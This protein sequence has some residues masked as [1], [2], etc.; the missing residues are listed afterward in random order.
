VREGSEFSLLPDN[1]HRFVL[2]LATTANISANAVPEP[3]AVPASLE[4][5][6]AA[7]MRPKGRA[8][9]QRISTLPFEDPNKLAFEAGG[10]AGGKKKA[11]KKPK[12][13]E[14]RHSKST[15]QVIDSWSV[16]AQRCS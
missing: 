15:K 5:P 11:G 13:D 6:V 14:A 7:P 16:L 4:D 10:K 2:V 1:T 3:T 9:L 8:Q 12:K